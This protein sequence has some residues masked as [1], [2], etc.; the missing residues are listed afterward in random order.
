MGAGV[1]ANP[2]DIKVLIGDDTEGV[3]ATIV[4]RDTELDLAWIKIDEPA[5]EPYSHISLTGQAEAKIGTPTFSIRRMGKFF[6]RVPVISEG[7]IG[8]LTHKPRDLYVAEG[9]MTVEPGL[10]VFATDGLLVGLF[11]VQMPE[12]KEALR[13]VGSGNSMQDMA[14][15]LILP[16]AEIAKATQRAKEMMAEE[17][18]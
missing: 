11:V 13:A 5:A 1:T 18:E 16:A 15:G 14:G 8:A 4:S 10:P 3:D 17:D 12:T 7:W 6:D 2:T 9:A